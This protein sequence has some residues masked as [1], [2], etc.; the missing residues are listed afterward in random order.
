MEKEYKNLLAPIGIP[1][2]LY[3]LKEKFDFDINFYIDKI[4]SKY[5]TIFLSCLLVFLI[6]SFF[7]KKTKKHRDDNII[8]FASQNDYSSKDSSIV[9][10]T[11]LSIGLCLYIMFTK[12]PNINIIL[13]WAI[14]FFLGISNSFLIK[15]ASFE[16]K[17]KSVYYKSGKEKRIFNLFNLKELNISP[18]EI[19]VLYHDNEKLISFLEI[20]E[21]DYKEIKS[22]FQKN[23]PEIIV[24]KSK[25]S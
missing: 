2:I 4:P 9:F 10:L 15:T 11:I 13:L 21:E 1:I 6:L 18:N 8:I 23:L 7:L 12:S 19:R 24:S 22:W 5:F 3:L 17:E 25:A 16:I 14:L 20:K